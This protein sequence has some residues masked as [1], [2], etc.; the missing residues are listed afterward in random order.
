MDCRKALLAWILL[1]CGF[2]GCTTLGG[3]STPPVVETPFPFDDK[4]QKA[5]RK[6]QA[7]T[8]VACGNFHCQ[9]AV[10]VARS[11]AE[12]EGYYDM[13]RK[14][15][16]RALELEPKNLPALQALARLYA[17]TGDHERAVKI[18]EQAIQANP[19][20][21]SLRYEFGMYYAKCKEWQPA[22][23]YLQQAIQLDGEN[24]LYV[25]AHGFC[26]ARAGHYEEG[27][28]VLA[29]VDGDALAHYNIARML[30]HVKEDELSKEHLQMALQVQP[31][32]TAA[33]Q[34]L[35]E[36]NARQDT[37]APAPSSNVEQCAKKEE[38][39]QAA[40]KPEPKPSSSA[41]ASVKEES[42]FDAVLDELEEAQA[43]RA[44]SAPTPR[45]TTSSSDNSG[46]PH[47]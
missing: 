32:L 35:L 3:P 15:Y 40:P 43:S 18:Y 41:K 24:R 13:A 33:G 36:L 25:R 8:F 4:D 29:K 9:A 38:P 12:R 37:K 31:N 44:D 45:G 20:E 5:D 34:L 10:D 47:K 39:R 2:I 22:L 42:E 28:A 17:V 1:A 30:H 27:F 21:A 26:L 11:S 6:P 23:E 16:Q 14:S 19:R 46:K 7:A